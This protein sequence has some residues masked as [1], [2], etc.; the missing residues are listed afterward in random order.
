ME[1]KRQK[2]R[3][4]NEKKMR[5]RRRRMKEEECNAPNHS[6]FE[7]KD[8]SKMETVTLLSCSSEDGE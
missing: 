4:E 2:G 8:E 7:R 5:K 6:S 3:R 1:G